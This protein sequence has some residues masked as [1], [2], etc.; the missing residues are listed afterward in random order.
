ML[1]VS[2]TC[3]YSSCSVGPV[4]PLTK[5]D[6]DRF[7]FDLRWRALRELWN[8]D[9]GI[10]R[11]DLD[12]QSFSLMLPGLSGGVVAVGRLHLNSPDEARIRPRGSWQELERP[13]AGQPHS[14]RLW[15]GPKL[16]AEAIDVYNMLI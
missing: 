14:S 7:T 13:W 11:D 10:E 4:E 6:C 3:C 2:P 5:T 1:N 16:N 12:V 9:T 8:S 15:K